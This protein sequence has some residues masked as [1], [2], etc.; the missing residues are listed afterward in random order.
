MS[1]STFK[2]LFESFQ[3]PSGVELK[4]RLV[5]APMTNFASHTDGSVSD[6]EVAYYIR[7]SGGV[8]MVI[9]ACAYVNAGGKGFSGE[10]GSD[11]DEMLPSLRRLA[12]AIKDEGALAVLQIFHGG[13]QCPPELLPDGQP[14][15][16][17]A[18]PTEQRGVTVVPRALEDAE[19]RGIIRDFG[20]STRRAIEA[21][22]DGVEIHGANGY[23]I[24]QF[25]SPYSNRRDDSWG[26]SLDKRLAFPLAI[27]EEVKRAVKEH[28]RGSFIG[29]Y[30]FSPEEA[31]TPGITMAET[32]RLIDE[33][34]DQGLDYLHVSLQEF[35]SMARRGAEERPRIDLIRERV[36]GRVPL[37]G[38]GSLFKAED[39]LKAR[40]S[41]IPLIALG[42]PLLIEPDWVQKAAEGRV[43]DIETE[44]DPTAQERLVLPDALWRAMIYSRGWFPVKS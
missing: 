16:A 14:V 15:S 10:F 42:R 18:V 44:L 26:G 23:L 28:A 3:L 9:T 40:E 22:F 34:A 41:G 27:V 24:Q 38:V 30:R 36:G 12:S 37:I 11:K 1:N 8:G 19:I 5:M 21:G 29:G 7:R 20:E 33:L 6:E 25:F 31:E 2:P 35:W 13:R 32:F 4:N 17:S 39:A 43:S